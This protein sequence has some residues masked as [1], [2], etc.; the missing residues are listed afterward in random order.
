MANMILSKISHEINYVS[1]FSKVADETKNI[2]KIKQ[3][4]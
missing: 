1:C 3:L 2:I 4:S